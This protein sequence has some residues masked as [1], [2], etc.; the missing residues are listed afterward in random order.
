[1]F[2]KKNEGPQELEE[3]EENEYFSE[4]FLFVY[5]WLGQG[6]GGGIFLLGKKELHSC[7][8][9]PFFNSKFGMSSKE[10]MFQ[11]PL[12]YLTCFSHF[13]SQYSAPNSLNGFCQD[14]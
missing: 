9:D 6:R 1:M 13:A 4:V 3:S 12:F 14:A 5:V 7:S 2:L 10:L 8:F 11:V